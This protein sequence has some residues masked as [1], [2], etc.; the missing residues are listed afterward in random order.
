[1]Q[2]QFLPRFGILELGLACGLLALALAASSI[3]E[4]GVVKA[5]EQSDAKIV[6]RED[7]V[8]GRVHGAG[9]LADIA[10]P[11]SKQP[12]PAIISVHGGRWV[13][14]HK[15]DA[16]TIKVEQWAGFGFFAM[17]IDYRLKNCS[18]APACYQDF[19]C[20]IRYV[21]AHTKE[22]NIDTRRIFL[23]GQSAG[24]HM[25][26]LAATLG[27]GPYPRT[28]GWE[29]ESNDFQAAISVAAAYDL[30]TLD[31]GNLWTPP[32]GDPVEARALASPARHVN[33]KSKPL[34]V[35]HSDND[36]SVPID[37]ALTMIE[38]LK[39]AGA[40]HTFHRYPEMGHMGI[41]DEV[42]ARTREFIR[43]ISA[44]PSDKK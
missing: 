22:Y 15:R 7:V 12:L 2:H 28:G 39:K 6:H 41:N 30:V 27:D 40:R 8:Y 42:I 31:W 3:A 43:E 24:G 33:G 10:Y 1:M 4:P 13:G 29:K 20:A 9:L 26:S 36:R 38:A 16:S 25:V 37:N 35:L 14:G 23:I 19:Q 34:L 5:G 18:P 32:G 11:E 21:N 17:S 44:K